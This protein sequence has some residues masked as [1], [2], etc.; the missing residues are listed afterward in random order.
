M[1]FGIE[2]AVH[3]E[4]LFT[5]RQLEEKVI[6]KNKMIMVCLDLEKAYD[7]DRELPWRVMKETDTIHILLFAD[8]LC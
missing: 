3:V 7:R 1:H 6:E 2:G 8:D 4:Q 5:I